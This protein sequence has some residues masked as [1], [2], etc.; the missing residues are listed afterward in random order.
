MIKIQTI[1]IITTQG[2]LDI[3]AYVFGDFALSK[4]YCHEHM[5]PGCLHCISMLDQYS[6]TYIPT[7]RL[8]CWT[9]HLH[10]GRRAI[11]QMEGAINWGRVRD[12][13]QAG[14]SNPMPKK[15]RRVMAGLFKQRLV[16]EY[17]FEGAA[18]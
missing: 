16:S 9:P 2:P 4:T 17:C 15:L 14:K 12:R 8:I 7:G 6:V 5:Q 3:P 18:R 11:R 1:T 10:T 13:V